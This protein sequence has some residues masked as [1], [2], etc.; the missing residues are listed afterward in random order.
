MPRKTR[1][2]MTALDRLQR[3]IIFL[4]RET[5]SSKEIVHHIPPEWH[6]LEHDVDV[7][8]KKQ[9]VTLYLDAPVVRY[10]RGMGNGYQERLNRLLSCLNMKLVDELKMDEYLE[11]EVGEDDWKS[12]KTVR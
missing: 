11:R 4:D 12:H 2:Q 6:T 8:P 9:K 1:A 5:W 7:E 10:F 3:D